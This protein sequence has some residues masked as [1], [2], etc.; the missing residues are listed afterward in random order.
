MQTQGSKTEGKETWRRKGWEANTSKCHVVLTPWIAKLVPWELHSFGQ[1]KCLWV[2]DEVGKC[3][4]QRRGEESTGCCPP[5][6]PISL[7]SSLDILAG[8]ITWP[9]PQPL[10][11]PDP[12]TALW[13]FM[14]ARSDGKSQRL[15]MLLIGLGGGKHVGLTETRASGQQAER[16]MRPS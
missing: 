16:K 7:S 14:G 15:N 13:S 1:L 10:G 6:S 9:F 11:K 4:K 8:D 5:L 2:G 12:T 3:H